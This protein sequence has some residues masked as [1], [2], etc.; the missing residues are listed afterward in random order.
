MHTLTGRYI[1]VEGVD[2]SGKTTMS[3][4]LAEYLEEKGIKTLL[5]IHPGA[6]PA[7]QRIRSIVKDPDIHL[8]KLT[9]ALL[10]GADNSAFI[11]QVLIP[12]LNEGTWVIADR[13]N[14]IS[15]LAYQIASGC[16]LDELDRIHDT[17]NNP[18]KADLLLILRVGQ[19]LAFDR[20]RRRGMEKD[21]FEDRMTSGS[22]YY[23]KVSEAYDEM[24]DRND[25]EFEKRLLKFV[26]TTTT[27]P[28]PVPRCLGVNASRS[29]DHVFKQIVDAVSPL[30]PQEVS[31][32]KQ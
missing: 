7:G 21:R 31:C 20:R 27:T 10:F 17:I 24:I 12:N 13:N 5:T 3:R 14:F 16:K 29:S 1:I 8:D 4:R 9:E 19:E 30:L 25:L 32:D 23:T 15:S 18:P 6:T 22:E 2:C 11:H 26:H 28:R